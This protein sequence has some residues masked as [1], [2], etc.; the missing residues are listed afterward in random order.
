MQKISRKIMNADR[1]SPVHNEEERAQ[2]LE[3]S[4][5][6]TDGK[7]AHLLCLMLCVWFM[8]SWVFVLGHPLCGEQPGRKQWMHAFFL[9][10]DIVQTK[11]TQ[12]HT[13]NNW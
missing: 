4:M 6:S 8:L 10:V 2:E 11:K 13:T 1:Y 3:L 9:V 5:S 12:D 7:V